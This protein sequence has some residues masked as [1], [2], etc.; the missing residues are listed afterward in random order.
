MRCVRAEYRALV[1]EVEGPAVAA[2]LY[3]P[4]SSSL[5]SLPRFTPPRTY[6]TRLAFWIP[7]ADYAP[8]H[9]AKRIVMENAVVVPPRLAQLD[10]LRVVDASE[11]QVACVDGREMMTGVNK[12]RVVRKLQLTSDDEAACVDQG[13]VGQAAVDEAAVGEAAVGEAVVGQAAVGQAAVDE[14][15]VGEAAVGEAVVGQAVVG[16]AAVDEAAVGEAAV[17]EAVV[18]QA[19]VNQAGFDQVAVDE[20]GGKQAVVWQ[21]GT[22]VAKLAQPAKTVTAV[23]GK[24]IKV[25]PM[26]AMLYRG[27]AYG[28]EWE[29]ARLTRAAA[30]LALAKVVPPA[31][32]PAVRATAKRVILVTHH[33]AIEVRASRPK[34]EV[35]IEYIQARVVP[36]VEP[37]TQA[38]ALLQWRAE[39]NPHGVPQTAVAVAASAELGELRLTGALIPPALFGLRG[40]APGGLA[41]SPISTVN[42]SGE[43]VT[44][45]DMDATLSYDSDDDPLLLRPAVA[46]APAP[47]PAP[48]RPILAV[49]DQAPSDTTDGDSPSFGELP[50]LSIHESPVR[51]P[52]MTARRPLFTPTP[53][54]KRQTAGRVGEAENMSPIDVDRR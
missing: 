51:P 11:S 3:F 54:G 27:V 30:G 22:M 33:Q 25:V 43:S 5:A 24:R 53:P 1:A 36:A 42:E 8:L 48:A 39:P 49:Y 34:H 44:D 40:P 4:P 26:R 52:R 31:K 14:A 9:H 7:P 28:L 47:A 32:P 35:A 6:P 2:R 19:A 41:L 37:A 17:G 12:P 15:A 16:Q 45:D 13:V 38:V 29:T 50:T 18:G 10:E 23:R 20:T 46:S 21:G